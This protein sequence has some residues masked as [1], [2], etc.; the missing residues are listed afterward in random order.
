VPL[1]W[2]EL[3]FAR[4]QDAVDSSCRLWTSYVSSKNYGIIT[5]DKKQR[6]AH[7]L[8]YEEFVGPLPK[9]AFV[10]HSC[11]NPLCINP[12]H[13][14]LGSHSDNMKDMSLKVR[15]RS[16]KITPEQALEIRAATGTS[17]SLAAKYGLSVS[18][19]KQIRAG[20]KWTSLT[21]YKGKTND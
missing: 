14:F 3:L 21:H 4:S 17:T 15:H 10:C 9:G 20:K 8:S 16:A 19:V 12:E 11:D 2:L 6:L 5:I 18:H 1:P 13:L 7:R